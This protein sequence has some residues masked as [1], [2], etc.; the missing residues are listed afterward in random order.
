M[1]STKDRLLEKA[2]RSASA[3]SGPGRS[4]REGISLVE[5]FRMFP[6]DGT[7]EAWFES[8]LWEG[9]RPCPYCGNPETVRT[10][11]KPTVPYRCVQCHSHFSVK[12]GTVMHRSKLGYQKW[13][14]AIYM[15]A[16][17]LKG[18]S[19]MKLHRDLHITQKSAW[20]MGQRIREAWSSIA[21]VQ[22]SSS[23]SE[24]KMQG[25]VE[26][27]ELYVGGRE[28]NKH[29][30][31]KGQTDK[32]IVVGVKD[33]DTNKV[34]ARTVPEATKARLE[35]FIE[36]NV[37]D[38]A[39][40]YTDENPS[41]GSLENHH[42]VNH[43]VGEY[44]RGQIHTNG[45]ESF[46][47]LLRRGYTGIYHKMSPE[48]LDRYVNEFAGRHNIRSMDTGMMMSELASS[49]SRKRLTYKRLIKHGVYA[50]RMASLE[51]RSP[52]P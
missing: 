42:T 52:M 20:F 29:A 8:I 45:M 40:K 24:E 13:A 23:S 48:H 14:I 3:G 2:L 11:H 19:S 28:K 18:V 51:Q 25:P 10:D 26:I 1:S 31:K 32:T 17:S 27:D 6:D 12:T 39:V 35:H 21:D 41:Y 9:G 46:W 4:E 16:T 47:A 36:T 34:T 38:G 44:V 50:H 5:L 33:R 7:A 43:S 15:F 37:S 22:S 30:D 49:M